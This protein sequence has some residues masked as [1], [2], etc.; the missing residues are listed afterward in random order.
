VLAIVVTIV[1]VFAAAILAQWWRSRSESARER[2]RL[3]RASADELAAQ[4]RRALGDFLVRT[5]VVA[6]IAATAGWTDA[7]LLA[8]LKA[9][10][11]DIEQADAARGVSGRDG[12]VFTFHD[13]GVAR[14]REILER[15]TQR[16]E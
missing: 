10:Y 8:A 6:R 1:G 3:E 13:S 12:D 2:L 14:L 11:A 9:M 5:D 4:A 7:T 15:R 16:A